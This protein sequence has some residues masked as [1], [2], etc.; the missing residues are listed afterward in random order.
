MLGTDSICV[1]GGNLCAEPL[2]AGITNK[3]NLVRVSW[4]AYTTKEEIKFVFDKIKEID[5]RTEDW[6]N[7]LPPQS[8]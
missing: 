5:E 8:T 2:V 7:T 1:R 3:N 6:G 4:A